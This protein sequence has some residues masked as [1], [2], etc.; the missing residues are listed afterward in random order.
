MYDQA[1]WTNNE[2]VNECNYLCLVLWKYEMGDMR[3][4]RGGTVVESFGNIYF[5]M[6]MGGWP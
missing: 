6:S 3:I 5:F 4:L 1:E 2:E